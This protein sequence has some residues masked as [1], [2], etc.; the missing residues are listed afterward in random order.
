MATERASFSLL[1]DG[2]QGANLI[3]VG[4]SSASVYE[5]ATTAVATPFVVVLS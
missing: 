5:S 1:M 4:E 2:D 3:V